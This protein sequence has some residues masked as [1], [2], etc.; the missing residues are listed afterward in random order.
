M[1][2]IELT[3][4]SPI[5]E[6]QWENIMDVDFDKTDRIWFQTKRG[7]TVE[8]IKAKQPVTHG[9][10]IRAMSDEELAEWLSKTR[11]MWECRPKAD[12]VRRGR[13]DADECD[14]CWLDWLQSPAEGGDKDGA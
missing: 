12:K 7:K 4:S 5:T 10:R 8:F 11:A 14:K 13:C 9:D 3:L 6:E 2:E 1:A